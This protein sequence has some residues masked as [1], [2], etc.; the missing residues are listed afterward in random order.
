MGIYDLTANFYEGE[1]GDNELGSEIVY[2][3]GGGGGGGGDFLGLST[4]CELLTVV[5]GAT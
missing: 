3:R 4:T 2:E 1:G 5:G